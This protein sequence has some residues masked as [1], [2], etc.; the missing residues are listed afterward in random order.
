MK[1]AVP[2]LIAVGLILLIV[3]GAVGFHL[4]QKYLPTKERA[5]LTTLYQAK[6]NETA[7]FFNYELEDVK[8]IYE[9]GQTYLPVSWINENINKRF[10]WDS[11]EQLLVYTLPDQI[12][13][14]DKDTKGSNGMPLLLLRENDVYL[15]LGLVANY[16]DV[17]VLAFDLEPTRRIYITD[18]GNRET[19]VVKKDGH[20]RAKRYKLVMELVKE[21]CY[22]QTGVHTYFGKNDYNGG[23][24][25]GN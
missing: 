25:I 16:P 18:W 17:Q 22:N 23:Y 12:V 15:T 21:L 9:N 10:Y 7:V 14:A 1:K 13:Y 3:S 19:A 6:G 20:V 2:I 5:D 4:V 11:T 8:G 24:Q